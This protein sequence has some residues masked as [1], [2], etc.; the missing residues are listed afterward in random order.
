MKILVASALLL[1]SAG[2]WAQED[3]GPQG[4]AVKMAPAPLVTAVQGKAATV[5]LSFRVAS[6]YHINSNQPRSE[7]LI[8][9]VLKVEATTDIVIGKTSYP[10][11][12]D[13][14]FAFAPDE[15]LNVYTGDFSVD[16][17]VRPLS[18]VQPGKYVVRGTL[19]Y[20]ACDNAACYP[21]KQ[22]PISFDVKIAR[23]PTTASKNPAQSP[24]AHP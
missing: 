11:G 24:H 4:P 22:L 5:P 17:L 2:I 3:F 12:K 21:P 7:F 16:V 23:A 13:M 14:S 20:Q 1:F 6:G 15:K 10:E 19:K 8:P 9:T 18:S